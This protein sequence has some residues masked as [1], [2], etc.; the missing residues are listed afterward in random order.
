MPIII[1]IVKR[2]FSRIGRVI[3][4]DT[5]KKLEDVSL[6]T[7]CTPAI[8][9]MLLQGI[10]SHHNDTN[11]VLISEV[12]SNTM[13]TIIASNNTPKEYAKRTYSEGGIFKKC[14]ENVADN[15]EFQN[16]LK[17]WLNPL[18]KSLE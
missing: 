15:S 18:K 5:E 11:L 1:N 3:T 6:I 16:I 2:V 12:I 13:K 8:G 14:V 17:N 10:N 4:V 9:A 7:G